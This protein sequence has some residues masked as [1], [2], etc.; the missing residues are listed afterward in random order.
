VEVGSELHE[1]QAGQ[2]VACGGVGY[3]N[4][5]QM[6][7]PRNLVVAVPDDVSLAEAACTTVGQSRCRAFGRAA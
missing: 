7:C 6:N 2:R 4:H 3:A 5:A 1:F